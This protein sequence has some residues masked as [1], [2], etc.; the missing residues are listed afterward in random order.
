MWDKNHPH[1]GKRVKQL[2]GN[3]V[4]RSKKPTN[5]GTAAHIPCFAWDYSKP[6]NLFPDNNSKALIENSPSNHGGRHTPVNQR[7]E[8]MRLDSTTGGIK[9]P[10]GPFTHQDN[11]NSKKG[12][13]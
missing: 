10:H 2:S 4:F 12:R 13:K 1:A 3:T 6:M 9:K 5:P 11:G 7:G 8:P